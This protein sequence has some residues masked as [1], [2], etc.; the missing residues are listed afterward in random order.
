V[1]IAE[2]RGTGMPVMRM[3]HRGALHAGC[4]VATVRAAGRS[5]ALRIVSGLRALDGAGALRARSCG[6]PVALPGGPQ[7]V[8]VADGP[9]RVDLLR[10]RSPAT[11]AMPAPPAAGRVVAPGT[12]HRASVSGVRVA[13]AR[14][15]WLVLGESYDRGWQATC[16]GHSLGAPAIVDGFANGWRVQPGCHAVRFVYGPQ[17]SALLLEIGSALACLLLLALLLVRR[18]PATAAVPGEPLAAADRP[19]RVA[20]GRAAALGLAAGVVLG[21]VLSIRAGVAIA[22]VT[23]IVLWAGVGARRLT[24]AAGALLALGVPAAYLLT[25]V[26]N[27]GGWDFNYPVERIAGHWLAIAALV[28]LL[29]AVVRT[30]A[31]RRSS[32]AERP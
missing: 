12:I 3:R 30:L 29:G 28:L 7:R 14:P 8:D 13:V 22:A 2:L 17:R 32:I 11:V 24:L 16:D 18:P 15:G 5:I 10:L 20:L 31:A 21:F 23:T 1:A 6:P 4:G 19:A 26:H 25:S 27:H 9:F